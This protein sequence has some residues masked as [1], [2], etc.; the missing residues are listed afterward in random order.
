MCSKQTR[1]VRLERL[2]SVALVGTH[3]NP[4][5]TRPHPLRLGIGMRSHWTCGEAAAARFIQAENRSH[6]HSGE[7]GAAAPRTARGSAVPTHLPGPVD[8]TWKVLR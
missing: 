8:E 6:I 2:L 5:P 4:G 3:R 7:V 1:Y